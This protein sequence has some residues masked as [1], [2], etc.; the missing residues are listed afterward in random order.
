YPSLSFLSELGWM[1]LVWGIYWIARFLVLSEEMNPLGLSLTIAG[2]SLVVLFGSQGKDGLIRGFVKGLTDLPINA[3]TGIGSLSDLV[4]YIRLFAVGLATKEVAV[5]F[6]NMAADAGFEGA[7]SIMIAVFILIFGHTINIMLA[8]MAVL[9]HG[10]RLNL[11]EFS[12][13]LN[14]EW[15]GIPFRPFKVMKE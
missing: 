10:I 2:M 8:A 7:V 9:V 6:N 15:S 5:A 13:H 4:S 11:L 12:R 1:A 3:L 14:I